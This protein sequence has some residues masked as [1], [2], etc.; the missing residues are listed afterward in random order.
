MQ[1]YQGIA[2]Q[3]FAAIANKKDALIL[4]I[5]SSCDE[6]AAAVV[7]GGR[8]VL[9]NIIASQIE[10]HKRFGGVV[11]EVASRNHTL[12]LPHIIDEALGDAG[13]R[14]ED[15]D[16]VAVTYG[17]GLIGALLVGLSS[18]KAFAY[19]QN[20]PLIAVNHI[21]A[22]VAA[23]YLGTELTPPFVSLVASGGHTLLLDISSYNEYTMLASTL[24]DALGEAF[25]KVARVLGLP[26]PGGPNV[27]KLAREGQPNIKLYKTPKGVRSDLMLSYSGLKTAVVNY[28]HTL[29]QKGEP[30]PVADICASF[31]H[32]AIDLLAATAAQA[33]K[34]AGRD[35][36]VLAGGV[37]SNSYLRQKLQET[38]KENGFTVRYPEPILCTD[39]AAM[40]ACRAYF[41]AAEGKGLAGLD[42]NA[43]SYL[44]FV[45]KESL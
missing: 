25:D 6:T 3:K 9:S 32:E 14:A 22:H 29:Q 19:A 12:A 16:A 45:A 24:D 10:I 11:P 41:M 8:R 26:Y 33:M 42:L 37:A 35:T 4:G 7:E 17:A 44:P 28:V 38:G 1:T 43:K 31:S 21:E 15:L 2:E 40:V 36:L 27:D 23:N 34:K 5:E 39:N 20:L 18:A 13:V 30:V